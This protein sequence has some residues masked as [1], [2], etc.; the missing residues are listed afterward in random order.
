[1]KPARKRAKKTR[2]VNRPSLQSVSG[3]PGRAFDLSDAARRIAGQEALMR[4]ALVCVV[5]EEVLAQVLA[6]VTN[7]EVV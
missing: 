3:V 7:K 1:M 4:V 2:K 6:R 5:K